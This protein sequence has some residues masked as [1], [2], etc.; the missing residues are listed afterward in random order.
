MTM[1]FSGITQTHPAAEEKNT[2]RKETAE[3]HIAAEKSIDRLRRTIIMQFDRYEML[4][5][6]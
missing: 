2:P 5:I 3:R 1:C 6:S 4:C